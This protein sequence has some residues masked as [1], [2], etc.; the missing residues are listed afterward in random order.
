[1]LYE[2][3]HQVFYFEQSLSSFSI[4]TYAVHVPLDVMFNFN[5]MNSFQL[6]HGAS[7]S[8]QAFFLRTCNMQFF[9]A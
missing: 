5:I 7:L 3:V 1:M 4:Y 9:P 2:F 8:Y 6:S